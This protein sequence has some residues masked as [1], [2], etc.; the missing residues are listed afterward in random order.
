MRFWEDWFFWA[1]LS[2]TFA[3]GFSVG[4]TLDVDMKSHAIK[5][6]QTENNLIINVSSGRILITRKEDGQDK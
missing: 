5:K 1:A 6:A 4:F 3:L 2:M